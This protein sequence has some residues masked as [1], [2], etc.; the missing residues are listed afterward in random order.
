MSSREK[1]LPSV[2][3]ELH[4]QIFGKKNKKCEFILPPYTTFKTWRILFQRY[5]LLETR[6][7]IFNHILA[8]NKFAS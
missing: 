5:S 4:H 2:E 1:G 6:G 8:G 7:D 3:I